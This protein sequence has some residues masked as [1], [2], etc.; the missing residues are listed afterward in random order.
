MSDAMQNN[1][2][3]AGDRLDGAEAIAAFMG[4]ASTRK[5]YSVRAAAGANSPIRRRAGMGFYAF[6]SEL[7][8]WLHADEAKTE[9]AKQAA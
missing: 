5:V 2:A 7:V 8:A 1:T 3:G 9:A 6:K 4:W